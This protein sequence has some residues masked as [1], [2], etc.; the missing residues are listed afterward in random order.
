MGHRAREGFLEEVNPEV[1]FEQQVGVS[2]IRKGGKTVQSEQYVGRPRGLKHS[3]TGKLGILFA[4]QRVYTWEWE[5]I[6]PESSG[7]GQHRNGLSIKLRYLNVIPRA[8]G[9]IQRL[10]SG[11]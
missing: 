4:V 11:K 7:N 10:I 9:A 5:Q 8:G 1:V 6:R 2:W 3:H